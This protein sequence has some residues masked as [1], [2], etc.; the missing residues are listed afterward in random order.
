MERWLWGQ[1][2]ILAVGRQEDHQ[3]TVTFSYRDCEDSLL[4]SMKTNKGEGKGG[5]GGER[6]REKGR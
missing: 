2:V 3:S 4:Y 5:S 6:E 1:T